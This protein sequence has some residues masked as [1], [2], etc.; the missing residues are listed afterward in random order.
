MPLGLLHRIAISVAAIEV[1]V[2]IVGLVVLF[3][4]MLTSTKWSILLYVLLLTAASDLGMLGYLYWAPVA[5]QLPA[6]PNHMTRRAIKGGIFSATVALIFS[7]MALVVLQVDLGLGYN[8]TIGLIA[9]FLLLTLVQD[10]LATIEV[11]RR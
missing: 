4:P 5:P 2:N 6:P 9:V 1:A 10:V 3:S 8:V 11:M 7:L